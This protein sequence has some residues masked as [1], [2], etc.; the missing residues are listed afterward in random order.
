[1]GEWMDDWPK[2]EQIAI[3]LNWHFQ[4]GGLTKSI[5]VGGGWGKEMGEQFNQIW[6]AYCKKE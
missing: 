5:F 6:G 3:S 1:M 4:N 2:R